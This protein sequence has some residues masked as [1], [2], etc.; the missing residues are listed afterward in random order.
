MP[1]NTNVGLKEKTK[2]TKLAQIQ[3]PGI[4]RSECQILMK[5]KI[6]EFT[7]E[8]FRIS[9]NEELT[10]Y[11]IRTN[12][13]ILKELPQ[14]LNKSDILYQDDNTII[15]EKPHGIPVHTDQNHEIS[16][17]E[18]VQK[19]ILENDKNPFATAQP[20]NRLDKETSGIVVYSKTTEA[21]EYYSSLFKKHLIN[22]EY[23]AVSCV[24]SENTRDLKIG[25]KYTIESFISSK[26]TNRKYI[27]TGER[28]GD[29][30]KTNFEVLDNWKIAEQEYVL[31]K[32]NPETG[33]THQLRVHL[34]VNGLPIAGDSIYTSTITPYKRLMLHSSKLEFTPYL[35]TV[36]VTI[37]SSPKWDIVIEKANTL[38]L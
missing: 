21:H 37:T 13:P 4:S 25:N 38:I 30:A 2:L 14:I 32:L 33:R 31:L 35:E 34:S 36:K 19:Y 29:F 16:L 23:T 12:F 28:F 18:Y 6:I 8:T 1:Y 15:V 27:Q 3:F 9:N 5:K 24:T 26:P 17:K 10:K 7:N 20:V 11:L 22:K